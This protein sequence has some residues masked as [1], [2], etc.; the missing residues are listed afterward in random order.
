MSDPDASLDA[1]TIVV[2]RLVEGPGGLDRQHRDLLDFERAWRSAGGSKERAVR[3]RFGLSST[4]Y[5]QLLM[6]TIDLPQALAYDPV[7]VRRLRRL[8]EARR[9]SRFAERL[10]LPRAPG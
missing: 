6:R 7:L 3:A 9:R 4:R 1:V 2:D 5:L 8:R 10:G